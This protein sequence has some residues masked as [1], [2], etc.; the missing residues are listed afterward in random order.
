MRTPSASSVSTAVT[1]LPLG[2]NLIA[3]VARFQMTCCRREASAR[4]W[5]YGGCCRTS[6]RMSLSSNAGRNA[7]S[8]PTSSSAGSSIANVS[9]SLPM[10][11]RDMSSRSEIMRACVRPLRSMA[12]RPRTASSL[13]PR[14][15]STCAQLRIALS[16]VRSSCD[17]TAMKSS[18]S[19][20][21]CSASP[22]ATRSRSSHRTRWR[23]S[24]MRAEMSVATT[25]VTPGSICADT[26]HST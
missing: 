19:R 7:P 9:G 17:S 6:R 13:P 16:G 26:L 4:I 25:I 18:F 20:L 3:L 14:F 1:T 11:R 12:A 23:S 10:F 2:E 24:S 5:R 15:F 8:A 22:R 21:V